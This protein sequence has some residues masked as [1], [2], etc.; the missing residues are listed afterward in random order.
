[1]IIFGKL[2]CCGVLL[3]LC[4]FLLRSHYSIHWALTKKAIG[5][6]VG[7]WIFLSFSNIITDSIFIP[8]VCSVLVAGLLCRYLA[9]ECL[10]KS[11]VFGFAFGLLY[12]IG[13]GAAMLIERKTIGMSKESIL[14]LGTIL[15]Y[16]QAT[17]AAAFSNNWR[18]VPAPMLRLLPVWLV[19]FL[20]CEEIIRNRSFEGVQTLTFL[21]FVWILY[22]GILLVPVGNKME[23][24]VRAYW[25]KQQKA[26][27]FALQEEYYEQLRDKQAE[28]RALWHD[29]NKYLRAAKAETQSVQALEQLEAMV[30]SATQIVD[31]GNPVLNVILNEYT[32]MTKALGIDLRLK[33]Q[34]PSNLP[35]T[36]ADLYILLG[37]TLDNA[38]EACNPLSQNERIIDL[39]LRLHNDI[40]YY[41][42]SNPYSPVQTERKANPMHGHGLQNV[43]RCVERYHGIVDHTEENGF[44][45][46]TAHLNMDK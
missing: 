28:T 17:L 19:A 15:V 7:A 16:A 36:V 21:S 5:L 3:S 24:S 39:T 12:L 1:M 42:L 2:L 8:F 29:L 37:N 41:K 20:L 10:A 31:V 9:E 33:V 38:M 4:L 32:Q 30:D 11:T 35:V 46:L 25:E 22:A 13:M 44:F 23:H 14:L 45:I 6:C 18:L 43:H 27:H 34:V 40:L 26:H